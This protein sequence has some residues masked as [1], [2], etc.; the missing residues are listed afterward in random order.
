MIAADRN[1]M[2]D[3]EI[4]ELSKWPYAIGS[5]HD[6]VGAGGFLNP[7]ALS[8]AASW[9][10]RHGTICCQAPAEADL[11]NEKI[12]SDCKEGGYCIACI[13]SAQHG[14]RHWRARPPTT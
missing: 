13:R 2:R 1:H 12:I 4:H 8:G 5:H 9:H 3:T 7:G 11:R 14:Q 10:Y 6:D